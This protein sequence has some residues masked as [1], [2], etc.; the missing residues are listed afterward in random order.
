MAV[1]LRDAIK[2]NLVQTTENTPAFVHTGCFANISHGTASVISIK[3]ALKLAEYVIVEAGF[4][5]DLGA[6][7]FVNLVARCHN[8]PIDT[9]CLVATIRALKFHGGAQEKEPDKGT[10][11]HLKKGLDNLR[12]HIENLRK[13]N[14]SVVVCLNQFPTDKE[15]EIKIVKGFCDY[16]EVPFVTFNG[17][18]NGSEGG[19]ELAQVLEEMVAK[20]EATYTPLYQ[21]SD[22]VKEK[23]GKVAKEIYGAA[24]VIYTSQAEKD[25]ER[26]Y[27]LKY[28]NLPIC[29]A[30]TN[31]SLS[32]NPSLYGVPRDFKI[33]ISRI[34]IFSGA[35]YLVPVAGDINLMPGL[36]KVPRAWTIDLDENG[37]ITG[38][39]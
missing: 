21:L 29:V 5:S 4:G 15:K 26:I 2:P 9:A 20:K 33:T 13:M 12:K 31:R 16:Q 32:D 8:L 22:G 11:S 18:Q 24:D 7:K 36:P 10:V 1:L 30:K 35:G 14:L 17:Y 3:I 39:K 6:E 37:Y 28:E 34:M 25:L 38:L 23:I 19:R 27:K